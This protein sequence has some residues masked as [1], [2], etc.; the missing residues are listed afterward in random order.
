MAYVGI[1]ARVLLRDSQRRTSLCDRLMARGIEAEPVDTVEACMAGLRIHPAELL[2]LEWEALG[3]DPVGRIRRAQGLFPGVAIVLLAQDPPLREVTRALKSGAYDL[4]LYPVSEEEILRTVEEALENRRSFMEI[5][6]LSDRLRQTNRTL[7]LQ[8]RRL[9]DERRRLRQWTEELNQLIVLNQEMMALLDPEQVVAV[10]LQ[11]I[12]DL[13]PHDLLSLVLW[14]EGRQYVTSRLPLAPDLQEELRRWG[15]RGRV[16]RTSLD[17]IHQVQERGE[18]LERGSLRERVSLVQEIRSGVEG[19]GRIGL[20]RRGSAGIP[21]GFSAHERQI[22]QVAAGTLALALRNARTHQQFQALATRD[23]LTGLWNRRAF[24]EHLDRQFKTTQRY[25]TP[26]S[27]ILVDVDDFKRINDTLGHRAG[28]RVLRELAQ[29]I[30][31][32]LREVDFPARYGG[33][34]LAILLPSTLPEQAAFVARR[35]CHRVAEQAFPVGSHQV[36]ITLSM[37]IASAPSSEIH[38]PEEMLEASDQALY[39]AKRLGRNRVVVWQAWRRPQIL[40]EVPV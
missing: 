3:Q 34:E 24:L 29:R 9:L 31:K 40:V 35:L 12:G 10:A 2:I 38:T 7:R 11:R 27:L 26:F 28:D 19:L 22:L 39:E 23:G 36:T 18:A 33:D 15:S 17:W 21:E 5:V 32:D 4:L 20:W 8:K 25:A 30:Q 14:E 1:R 6:E 16:P 37:G 13:I